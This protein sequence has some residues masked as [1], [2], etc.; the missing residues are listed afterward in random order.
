M[1]RPAFTIAYIANI[2]ECLGIR[3]FFRLFLI[4]LLIAL[5]LCYGIAKSVMVG[6]SQSLCSIQNG[7]IKRFNF[8]WVYDSILLFFYG[9][10][11]ILSLKPYLI[12]FGKNS[13]F[14]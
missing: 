5:N 3:L 8:N 9:F 11:E 7:L 10:D 14:I 12:V 6:G 13:N 4:E 2:D 1:L